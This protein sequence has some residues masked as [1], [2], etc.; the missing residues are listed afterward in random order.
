MDEK[1]ATQ[2]AIGLADTKQKQPFS[3][4]EMSQAVNTV[5]TTP[6]VKALL[7]RSGVA[8]IFSIRKEATTQST[9]S[10]DA[11]RQSSIQDL[12]KGSKIQIGKKLGQGLSV[13]LGMKVDEFDNKLSLKNDIELSYQLKNGLLFTTSQGL[14]K[15]QDGTR[16]STYFLQ[17]YWRFGQ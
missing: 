15:E 5:L 12:Y 17:K 6:F 14:G 16:N 1:L 9:Q 2:A 11:T 4:D 13:N 8:D 3:M 10:G 7:K